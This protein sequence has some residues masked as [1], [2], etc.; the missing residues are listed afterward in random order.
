M[1]TKQLAELLKGTIDPNHRNE[2]EKKLTEL[3]KIIGFGPLVLQIVMGQDI[4]LPVRQAAVIYLKNMVS[5]NWKEREP[6]APGAPVPFSIHEQDRAVIR[7]NIVEAV[8]HAPDII[9]VQLAVCVSQ[10]VKHDFPGRW[11]QVVDKVSIYLQNPE[12]SGWMGSLLCL[13]QLTKNFEYKKTEERKPL[14]DAMNLLLPQIYTLM[15][16]MMPDDSADSVAVQKQILKIFFA[17]TQYVLPLD[18]ISREVFSN[19]MEI[20]R[21]LAEVDVPAHTLQADEEDRPELIWW[22]RK[23]WAL[24]T[25]T[26]L[27]ER[28]GSPGSVTKEYKEF[29]EWF[30][31]TFSGG[32]LTSMLTNLDQYRQKI[33]VSPRVMQQALNYINTAVSHSHS[34]KLIKPHMLQI[35]QDIVF[36]LMSYSEQDA[37]LWDSDPYEYIRIK[38]DIFEDF[39]SPVTAAQTLLHSACK[40]RKEMLQKTMTLLLQ[41][42]QAPGTNPSQKDGALHM[43]GTMADILLKKPMYKEQMEK[44]LVEI[45]FREFGSPHGHLRARACWVLH[46]FSDVKYNNE[47]VLREA[48]RL[49]VHCLLHDSEAPV[50]V[51][52]AIAV[53]MMLTSKGEAARQY[54]E[55]QIREITLEL[56]K[57]IRE[58]ENDDLTS[59]MQKIVCTYTEQLVPVAVDICQHLVG[60]FAQVLEAADSGDEKAIT[61]MGLLNTMETIL[62]VME[63]RAEVH[64]ALEPVVLQA[65]H[66]IF[67]NSIMEFYEEA[68]SLTCDLT[69]KAI[70]ENMWK[71]LEVMYTVFQRDGVD[72]FTDMMPALHNYVT[73]DTVA[74]LSTPDYM[75]AMYNM[76][77][78]M[79]ESDPGE[80]PE[81]HAAKLLEVIILQCKGLNIDQVI[82]IFIELV[83][84]RLTREVKTSELRTM[85]LQVIIAAMYYNPVLLVDTLDKMG[86]NV[87][88]QFIQQWIHDT[89]CFIGLHDRKIC[90]LGLCH[91]LQMPDKPAIAATA[92]QLVP[93][94]IL[95]FDGLKRAYAAR[96]EDDSDDEDDD[97]DG[98]DG[99]DNEL[100]DSD[101]DELDDDGQVYLES[102]QEK[103]KKAGSAEG[104]KITASIEDAE[105]SE[106]DLSDDDYD[107]CEETSLEAY[108]TPLDDEEGENVD[109]YNIF[110]EVLGCIQTTNPSWYH[111]LT[112][113]LSEV[114]GKALTEVITLSNQRLAERESRKIQQQGGYQFNQQVVPGQFNFGAPATSPFV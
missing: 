11:P 55:P 69:T 85:C 6:D 14:T 71:M 29:A 109:E 106:D 88:A 32:I 61:A 102:L 110:K 27:F 1:D 3:H 16:Q 31:K 9:R 45:V 81:C 65:I 39:V 74:F 56:L 35:I 52:A 91:L 48:F 28:Y 100:L 41:I 26:R 54:L 99:V 59:V 42:I 47:T 5:T 51:E 50:K 12:P 25:L 33:Y 4:E 82:P 78:T 96:N 17:L 107:G 10:I 73:V 83:L 111:Q 30:L 49:T 105:D 77:R 58:T 84:K 67:T 44:F 112:S 72:Y 21:Q 63:E 92:Q 22:K 64:A 66:H 70:S 20:L 24:H 68:M 93:S 19:W 8:V 53:Q 2:A 34:W 104:F 89:D 97:E 23:K 94:I 108:T 13:Y 103:V 101:E 80:D 76:A 60:T 62:G 43:I 95:L 75:M 86:E 15:V 37:E 90:V 46:Y 57:I 18:L 87:F 98:E 40:K 7:D 113:H 79:L 36:P 38:F 114:Q